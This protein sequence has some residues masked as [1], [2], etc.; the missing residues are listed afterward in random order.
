MCKKRW[1]DFRMTVDQNTLNYKR[2]R[3]VGIVIGA[4]ASLSALTV[5]HV[6]ANGI[7]YW[8]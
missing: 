1:N 8:K 4:M 3:K 2:G 5:A 7:M 6:V